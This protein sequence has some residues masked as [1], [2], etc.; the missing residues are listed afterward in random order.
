MEFEDTGKQKRV[1]DHWKE[2]LDH[3]GT[4]STKDPSGWSSK[5]FELLVDLLFE[6]SVCLGY[7]FEKLRIKREAYLPQMFADIE[8]QQHALRRQLLELTDG[9]GRRKLPVALFEQRFPDLAEQQ[10]EPTEGN[11]G[12]PR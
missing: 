5:G 3:L 11:Y 10:K 4:D 8:A 2:Y 12:K 6:M 9:T 7:D 1:L